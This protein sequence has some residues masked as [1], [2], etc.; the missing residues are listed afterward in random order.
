MTEIVLA[1]KNPHKIIEIQKILGDKDIILI[2]YTQFINIEI[3]EPNESLFENS[4]LKAEIIYKLTNKPSLA[5]DSGLFIEKLNG[6]PGVF[7][8]RYGKNDKERLKRVLT[9]LGNTKNRR[10]KFRAVFVYYYASRKY[11][12]FEGEIKGRIA[13]QPQGENGFGYDPIFI[14]DGYKKTFA[15]LSPEEKNRISHRAKALKKFK[16][17]LTRIIHPKF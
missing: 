5:D 11:A 7:S 8:S 6:A 4:L 12:V 3:P 17:Y 2:P 14:P 16:K 10:A 13:F 15:E 1:T 9:E